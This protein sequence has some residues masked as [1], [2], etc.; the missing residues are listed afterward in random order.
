MPHVPRQPGPAP[1]L[2][3]ARCACRD[4]SHGDEGEGASYR[5]PPHQ[6]ARTTPDTPVD[7]HSVHA[8]GPGN[9]TSVLPT[10]SPEAS[11]HMGRGVMASCLGRQRGFSGLPCPSQP[12]ALTCWLPE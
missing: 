12:P 10:S 6:D 9:G 2:T 3:V 5:Q 4:G 7:V 11:Q 8:Q 1:V